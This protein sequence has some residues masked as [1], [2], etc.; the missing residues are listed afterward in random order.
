VET[1]NP[2]VINNNIQEDFSSTQV[3]NT[4][5]TDTSSTL[6][7][8]G[9]SGESYVIEETSKK[10]S[11]GFLTTFLIIVSILIVLFLL[12][13]FTASFWYPSVF[14]VIF[15]EDKH[16]AIY[17]E[18]RERRIP[19]DV[20]TESWTNVELDNGSFLVPFGKVLNR[21]DGS[22]GEYSFEFENGDMVFILP[23]YESAESSNLNMKESCLLNFNNFQYASSL[24][25]HIYLSIFLLGK[26]VL[27]KEGEWNDIPF[28]YEN[29]KIFVCQRGSILNDTGREQNIALVLVPTSEYPEK[30]ATYYQILLFS[31]ALTQGEIDGIVSSIKI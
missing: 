19:S 18:P 14:R 26:E 30:E 8:V 28:Y 25:D 5:N 2:D 9:I 6:P 22:G 29:E 27:L 15:P 4:P 24:S 13:N 17:S 11:K 10:K 7:S 12:L 16:G 3:V 31:E 21:K 1:Q 20:D 23:P